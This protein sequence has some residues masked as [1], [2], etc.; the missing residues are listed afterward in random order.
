MEDVEAERLAEKRIE[1]FKQAWKEVE[2]RE[3]KRNFLAHFATYVIVNAF[4]SLINLL[5]SPGALWVHWV[6][7]AW[8]VGLVLHFIFSREWFV[9][10]EWE[11]KAGRVEIRFREKSRK[12]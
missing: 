5:T 1:D 2:V 9:V 7:L 6:I 11:K 3:A 10:A 12:A 8:G 4:L